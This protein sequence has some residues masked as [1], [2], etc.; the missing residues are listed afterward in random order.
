[1]KSTSKQMELEMI[2]LSKVNQPQKD[3]Y[4]IYLLIYGY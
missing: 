4:G 1:M 2:I 3:K